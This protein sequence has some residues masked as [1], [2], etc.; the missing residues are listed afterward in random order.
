[1]FSA[2]ASGLFAD[3]SSAYKYFWTAQKKATSHTQLKRIM[4][5][6]S[7]PL[8]PYFYYCCCR[9]RMTEYFKNIN[10]FEFG[11]RRVLQKQHIYRT[12]A[13]PSHENYI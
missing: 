10:N 4:A 13:N 11:L 8:C 2:V 6:A 5:Q 1:M 9:L 12:N 7:A 3:V